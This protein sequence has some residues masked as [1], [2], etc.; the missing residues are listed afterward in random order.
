MRRITGVLKMTI[1]VSLSSIS[2]SC[3]SPLAE[4]QRRDVL[5]NTVAVGDPQLGW[6]EDIK[7]IQPKSKWARYT[8]GGGGG[9]P[10]IA[11][12][13]TNSDV[14]YVT[15]D[16]G[17]I[18]KSTDGGEHWFP[19]NNNIGNRRLGDVELDPLNPQVLYV[20]A[21]VYAKSPDW[22]DDPVNGELYRSLDGGQHW[23][24]VYAEGM[25]SGDGRSFGIARWPS[26]RNILLPYDPSDPDRYD[27]DADGLTDVIY[28]G[29][30]DWDETSPDRRAGIWK[31][32][33]EG[34]TFAQIA[35]EDKNIWVLR[36]DPD[37]PETLYVGT[38]GDGLFVS[39]DGGST[40]EDW[41]QRLPL[42]MISDIAIVPN[43]DVLYVATNTFYSRYNADEY[44]SKRGLYKSTD[45]GASFFPINAGLENTSLNF[46]VLALDPTDPSGQ[47][48]YTGPWKGSNRSVY[49]T[50]DGGA[51]WTQMQFQRAQDPPW[52]KNFDNLWALA[53]ADDGTMFATTWRGIY[54]YNSATQEWE[55]KVNGLGNIGVRSI[56][57]EPGSDDTIYLGILDST[58]WKSTDGGASW[59][60]I[61]DGF[62]TADGAQKANASDFAISPS[63]PQIIYATGMG[64]SNSYLSAV[65]KS[66]DGGNRW[67]PITNG[68]PPS[69][70]D[71]PQWQANAI[72]VSAYNPEIAYVALEMSAGGGR[73][74]KTTDGGRRWQEI[75]TLPE[76]P[77]DLA[78][79]AT[80][81][82]TVVCVTATGTIYIGRD[83]GTQWQSSSLGGNL[84]YSVDLFPTDPDRILA[85]VNVDGAYLTADGGRSWQLIFD[86]DDLRPFM[87][88]I[89]LSDFARAR[90]W[91]TI[92]VARFDP[93]DPDTIYLGHNPGAWMGVGILKSSDGGQTW[94]SLADEGF[95]MRSVRDF[96]LDP[97]SK[98]LAVGTHEVYYYHADTERPQAP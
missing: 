85:G 84:I 97:E 54:R 6:S 48:L 76:R 25:G 9:Q 1:F 24:V 28:V 46:E 86:Q 74:Y 29:G 60:N 90:Y 4:V 15:T 41:S 82:E 27:A 40:W 87:A 36:Q 37:D 35:L 93:Y 67:N 59:M 75:Y 17:G 58:P 79:S 57:F 52:F 45:G 5:E 64:P 73:I 11:V 98:D 78:I 69:P 21:E 68:L 13:P 38:Y 20:V 70:S 44:R 96:D 88:Q 16:N 47:T 94:T 71:N 65:N 33:D 10:G 51:T 30:W 81:P 91:P 53:Q 26:T 63:H 50:T 49:R 89:A 12:D 14:V 39:R 42:P 23:E 19:I 32:T 72:V 55:I 3:G 80:D 92:R 95:Q 31:S 66:E 18:V 83:G 61:G 2:L 34:R 8:L 56:A 7:D 43:S 22:I 62:V 77:T